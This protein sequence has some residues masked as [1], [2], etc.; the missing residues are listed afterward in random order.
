MKE[1][2]ETVFIIGGSAGL[3][4]ELAK[5]LAAQG[6][7]VTIFARDQEK[8]DVAK[9]EIVSCQRSDKQIITAVTA[10][11][12]QVDT[13]Y[14]V[15]SAQPRLPDTLYCVAGGTS[16]ELGFLVDLEPQT[17]ERCMN[18]N[19]YSSL[20]PSQSVLRSW[21]NDDKD[22]AT[23]AE[24]RLRK[25]IFVNSSASLVPI[26]GYI[27]YSAAKCAQRALADTLR[28]EA[29]RYSSA[30]SSYTVQCIFAHNYITATFI[31]E[32]RNKPDLTKRLEGTTGNLSEIQKSFP[33]ADKIA[34]EIIANV[35]KG[36]FAVM[37]NRFEP[38]FC[39]ATSIASSPKRGWGVWDTLLAMFA[40]IVFPLFVRRG[41]ERECRGDASRNP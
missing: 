19:F 39:W 16:T 24:P 15:L 18:K 2:E 4:K 26:P 13:V 21:I 7:H 33:Y 36:D 5:V 35:A 8:L 9:D 37:D 22:A 23:T 6:A 20:Y 32:Q 1:S 31:E 11:M 29:T 30:V 38:Q 12:S 14:E 41:W 34:P 10:D 27:A 40:S 28:M 17:F 3:G 25:I